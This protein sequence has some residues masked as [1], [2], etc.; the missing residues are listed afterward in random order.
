MNSNRLNKSKIIAFLLVFAIVSNILMPISYANVVGTVGEGGT[1]SIGSNPGIA[2]PTLTYVLNYQPY[3]E[4]WTNGAVSID[5]S[6]TTSDR[7]LAITVNGSLI[8]LDYQGGKYVGTYLAT[9]NGSYV[10]TATDSYGGKAVETVTVTNIDKTPPT[11][12]EPKAVAV[13]QN[14]I[15]IMCSQTD[16]GSGIDTI[17]Y[18]ITNSSGTTG[19]W[20]DSGDFT[21]LKTSTVYYLQTK[22]IDK[23]GNETLSKVLKTNTIQIVAFDSEPPKITYSKSTS[24]WTNNYVLVNMNITDTYGVKSVDVNGQTISGSNNVYEFTAL[25]NGEYLVSAVDTFDNVARESIIINNID[26]TKP[27]SVSPSI[28]QRTENSVTVR[29]EQQDYESGIVKTRYRLVKSIYADSSL[30]GYDWIEKDTAFVRF[31]GLKQGTEYFVQTESTDAAGNIQ[32]SEV[33]KVTTNAVSLPIAEGQTITDDEEE[34]GPF[35]IGVTPSL[36]A[37]T[38]DWTLGPVEIIAQGDDWYIQTKVNNGQWMDVTNQLAYNYGDRVYARYTDGNGN[39][40]RSVKAVINNID[41]ESPTMDAPDVELV[42]VNEAKVGFTFKQ[43]DNK[44]GIDQSSILYRLCDEEGNASIFEYDWQ[45]SNV[46]SHLDMYKLYYVQT[47]CKD[48]LGNESYSHTTRFRIINGLVTPGTYESTET[49]GNMD[50]EVLPSDEEI[51]AKEEAE[52]LALEALSQPRVVNNYFDYSSTGLSASQYEIWA[53]FLQGYK[54]LSSENKRLKNQL[55]TTGSAVNTNIQDQSTDQSAINDV[56]TN[57]LVDEFRTGVGALFIETD[58]VQG[59][60]PGLLASSQVGVV[61]PQTT[62][63]STNANNTQQA[64]NTTINNYVIPQTGAPLTIV[65]AL[66]ALNVAGLVSWKKYKQLD[67]K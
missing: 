44:S 48:N 67:D 52:R 22:A 16:S 39:Y 54:E 11:N 36:Y 42:N 66:L 21:N 55:N 26:R 45:S 30:T 34:T 1:S 60:E 14:R 51:K 27:T 47:Y 7:I 43:T 19:S 5:V 29:N 58:Q 4:G 56:Q 31:E 2:P 40:G 64:D 20:V 46:M 28:Y 23:A 57:A 9:S 3:T 25:E 37:N 8:V 53:E 13:E 24:N 41:Q 10:I 65:F 6:A 63:T 18:R 38:T 50:T 59:Q 49:V 35:A 32:L 12:N 62:T 17:K 15:K 61:T 33:T